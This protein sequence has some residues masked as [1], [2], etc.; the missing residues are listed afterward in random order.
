[1]VS[2]ASKKRLSEVRALL[3]VK[4]RR[5]QRRFA[6][7]GPTLLQEAV[8]AALAIDAIYVTDQAGAQP[9]LRECAGRGMPMYRLT[10]AEM[11][12]ISDVET[13]SGIVA[14]A[15]AR[16]TALDVLFGAP[17]CVLVL[18][19]VNDP[20]NAG[21]LVRAAEAFGARGVV[22]GAGGVAP[23]HPK[24]VRSAMGSLFRLSIAVATPASLARATRAWDVTGLEPAGVPLVQLAWTDRTAIVVGSER[25][26]LGAWR[27]ACTRAAA[28]PMPGSAESLNAAV[29]GAI[30]LYE[31]STRRPC[32]DSVSR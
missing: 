20:G 31:Y 27:E 4:G 13:P 24:V 14:V 23:Y 30:A 3:T 22:F 25:H 19:A 12:S 28:I 10:D 1:V 26:G 15:P 11:R 17:G 16:Q 21:T 18:A 9:I 7:E 2:T 32:Q 29:A 8:H 6:F 5:D